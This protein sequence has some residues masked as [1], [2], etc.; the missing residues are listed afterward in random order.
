MEQE[1]YITEYDELIQTRE[2]QMLKALLPIMGLKNQLPMALL[3]QTMEFQNTIKT[4]R[5]N[6]NALSACAINDENDKKNA[7]LQVL[8]RF[9]TPKERETIDTMLNIMCIAENYESFL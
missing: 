1:Q 9:C 7:I 5:N 4:F 8:R 3:I 2:L 6:E